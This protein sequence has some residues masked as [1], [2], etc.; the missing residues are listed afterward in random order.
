MKR[1]GLQAIIAAI[2]LA[3]LFAPPATA[4]VN[5]RESTVWGHIF[6]GQNSVKTY[7]ATSNSGSHLQEKSKIEVTYNNFPTWAQTDIQA[8]VDVWA[9]NF[10]SSVPI[11][12]DAT[13]GRSQVYGL[14]GSARPGNYFNNFVN[15]PDP[16]LWYPSAL[17]NALA[18]RDLDKNNPEIVIQV[19][20]AAPW[21]TRNDGKPSLSEYDLQSV[22][23]HEIG[24][25]LVSNI[26]KMTRNRTGTSNFARKLNL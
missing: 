6:A 16:T 2:L 13:W 4:L 22:F 21:D 1:R 15:A 25:G 23:I 26:S 24:H 14:L 9:A 17:A 12:V 5:E 8:A 20:S 11:K 18:G 19:N 3:P 10:E 7:N